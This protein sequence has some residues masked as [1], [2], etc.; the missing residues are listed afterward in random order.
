MVKIKVIF[1]Y[2]DYFFLVLYDNGMADVVTHDHEIVLAWLK[3]G[4]KISDKVEL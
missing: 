4:G 1:E 3:A 2:N